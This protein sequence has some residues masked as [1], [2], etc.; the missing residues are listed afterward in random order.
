MTANKDNNYPSFDL[1]KSLFIILEI[2]RFGRVKAIFPVTQKEREEK[3]LMAALERWR[4][5]GKRRIEDG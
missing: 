2:S 5:T 4:S 3:V 1:L